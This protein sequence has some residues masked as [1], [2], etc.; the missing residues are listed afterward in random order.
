MP[1]VETGLPIRVLREPFPQSYPVFGLCYKVSYE[2]RCCHLHET[3]TLDPLLSFWP[4][5][6]VTCVQ[7]CPNCMRPLDR[8][9]V[10]RLG[11][12]RGEGSTYTALGKPSS[13]RPCW[14][15]TFQCS[16]FGVTVLCK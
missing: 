6:P 5:L 14:V 15:E 3:R 13:H 1:V 11:R 16:C 8:A 4:L 10:Y 2:L 7:F 12:T 9:R